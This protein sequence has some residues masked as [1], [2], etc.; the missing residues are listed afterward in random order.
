MEDDSSVSV[1]VV[2]KACKTANVIYL[3]CDA[4]LTLVLLPSHEN[5]GFLKRDH[6]RLESH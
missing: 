4:T 6:V 3:C 2:A 1:N 5:C